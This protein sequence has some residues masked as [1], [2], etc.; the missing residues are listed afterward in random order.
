MFNTNLWTWTYTHAR[1]HKYIYIYIYMCVYVCMCVC[2]CMYVCVCVC[3]SLR[4]CVHT[5]TYTHIHV[6][7]HIDSHKRIRLL[8]P[9]FD[10]NTFILRKQTFLLL[11]W[12][13]GTFTE[14]LKVIISSK[15]YI[16]SKGKFTLL[17]VI[18]IN[19]WMQVLEF[20]S[21]TNY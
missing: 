3:V 18:I 10:K 1:T 19:N 15:L 5:N 6:Y 14:F 17:T 12:R 4:M 7:T 20:I 8:Y 9:V 16:L 11:I 21:N 2:V 13:E